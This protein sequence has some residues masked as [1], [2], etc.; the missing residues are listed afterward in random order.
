[1]VASDIAERLLAEGRMP[2]ITR[3][4]GK[5]YG[6]NHKSLVP[7]VYKGRISFGIHLVACVDGQ[8]YDPMIGVKPVPVEEYG[9]ISFGAQEDNM[10][11]VISE[12]KIQEFVDR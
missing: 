12:E 5:P 11:V 3:F 8:A 7:Q 2:H 1:M 4:R 10:D 9:K 6:D